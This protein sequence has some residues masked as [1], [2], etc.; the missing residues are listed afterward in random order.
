MSDWR[1]RITIQESPFSNTVDNALNYLL[2]LSMREDQQRHDLSRAKFDRDY[3][4]R[5]EDL[6]EIREKSLL[7]LSAYNDPLNNPAEHKKMMEDYGDYKNV[8]TKASI[9]D[10][11]TGILSPQASEEITGL[12][13]IDVS[14]LAITSEDLTIVDSWLNG[15]PDAFYTGILGQETL[16]DEER[17]E[18]VKIGLLESDEVPN[19][20]SK[21]WNDDMKAR[22]RKR[23]EWWKPSFKQTETYHETDEYRDLINEN[24]TLIQNKQAVI[25]NV[26]ENKRAIALLEAFEGDLTKL[27]QNT[28]GDRLVVRGKLYKDIESL[29]K[30]DSTRNIAAV[31]TMSFED[32]VNDW[33][34]V[35]KAIKAED[36]QFWS[37]MNNLVNAYNTREFYSSQVD[38]SVFNTLSSAEAA[39]RTLDKLDDVQSALNPLIEKLAL[40]LPT[41]PGYN[42]LQKSTKQAVTKLMQKYPEYP[43]EEIYKQMSRRFDQFNTGGI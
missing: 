29:A 36:Q 1:D 5:R 19:G 27:I 25:S 37:Q 35:G 18:L 10:P 9:Y 14:P 43:V 38:M 24:L 8:V 22:V 23:W 30:D 21:E 4:S 3:T 2:E 33:D 32:I 20:T 26:P 31:L 16:S 39:S 42:E 11:G 12:S 6:Q 7:D 15:D 13:T 28:A 34:E 41:S 17:F 40:T